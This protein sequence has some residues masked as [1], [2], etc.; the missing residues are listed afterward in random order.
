MLN[1]TKARWCVAAGL[2]LGSATASA[3][4]PGPAGPPVTELPLFREASQEVSRQDPPDFLRPEFLNR[5][6]EKTPGDAQPPGDARDVNFHTVPVD[7]PVYPPTG[8]SG[9]TSVVPT[10]AP[11]Q[12]FV[13]MPDRWRAGYPEW[14]RYGHGD[15]PVKDEPYEIGRIID[16]YTQNVLKGDYPII[17]QHTFLELTGTSVSL[18]EG[19]DLPTM[20]T[21]FESTARPFQEEFFGRSGQFLYSQFLFLSADVFHGNAAF[22]P[23]D[24]RVKVTGAFNLNSLDVGEVAVV[25]P[26][27]RRGSTRIRTWTI[28]QEYFIE[29]KLA[30]L[31]AAYDFV[32]MRAG[33]QLFVSDFRGFIFADVNRA[34]RLF[35]TRNGNRDQFN[36]VYFD[37]LEKDTN[38]FLNTFDDRHQNVLIANYYHQDF[39]VPGYTIQGSVHWNNDAPST[40]YDVNDFLVRPDPV[41]VFQEHRVETVYLGINGD[42]H[43]G[44]YNITNSF[45]QVMGRDSRNP[46]AGQEVDVS[47]Q[48][49][50]VELS[51]DRD[52]VRFRSSF[53]WSSGDGDITNDKA[54]GFD[55]I[56]DNPNF[57]GGQFSYWQRQGIPL[58]GIFL[59]QRNSL[60]PDM[61]SSK[62]QGQANHVNPGL[63]LANAGLD[64]EVTPK[65]RLINNANFLWFDKTNVIE[66]FLFQGGIDREIGLDL[67]SGFEYRPLLSNNIIILGGLAALFPANGLKQIY[68]RFNDELSPQFSGFVQA[69]LT[70]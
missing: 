37:Q 12:D 14:D 18:F 61:R 23:F 60:I 26:D 41:G 55:S 47:A 10:I 49:A 66:Q 7:P 21:P 35:G 8:F 16:P 5:E 28:P 2:L 22:K 53:F 6:L 46:L 64:V 42:G 50:A 43:F 58:F 24:W 33:S 45:Y 1:T 65:L 67:S 15:I 62:I 63:F 69:V 38:S 17:G 40:R 56:I 70:Y 19:R 51:Y 59:N 31:S 36:L 20:T 39:L 68:N 54:T 3:Q 13:P 25:S 27:V 30:D 52:W 32:S 34:V 9:R 57:A 48:M 29:T 11:S 44:R 4:E